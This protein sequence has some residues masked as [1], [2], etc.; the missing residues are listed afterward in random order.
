[1]ETINKTGVAEGEPPSNGRRF[2]YAKG[3]SRPAGYAVPRAE[4]RVFPP[5]PAYD[6][7]GA[8]VPPSNGKGTSYI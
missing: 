8:S 2:P 3:V 4:Q 7:W 6:I 1:M 5:V